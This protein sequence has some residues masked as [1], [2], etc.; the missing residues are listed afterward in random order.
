MR[1]LM[2]VVLFMA[3]SG[4]VS[5]QQKVRVA[6]ASNFTYAM[7]KLADQFEQ[8]TG[9]QLV[10]SYGSSGKLYAQIING[11]PFDIFLSADSTRPIKLEQSNKSTV[12]SRFTYARG[13][14]V[15]WSPEATSVQQMLGMLE[16]GRFKFVAMANPKT[17]PY[18]YAAQQVM[19]Q[20]G[21][22]QHYTRRIVK[23][24]NISQTYQFVYS[25][26][27]AAG[28][29]ARAQLEAAGA[30]LP[31]V[32]WYIPQQMYSAIEQQAILLHRGQNNSAAKE[33]YNFLQGV[34]A[35][36]IISASGY[37]VNAATLAE[38]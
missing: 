37:G 13:E 15:L 34:E 18:G 2:I 6:V 17:A 12:G 19:K 11:A 10:V 1:S 20:L 29:I 21:I 36:K 14:L 5:A 3:I 9:H 16:Q 31:G 22:A 7:E 38:R 24:E 26:N 32:V 23:G 8:Q 27:A 28:F 4:E 33:F 25:G 35:R 30:K